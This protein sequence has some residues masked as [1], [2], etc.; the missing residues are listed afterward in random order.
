MKTIRSAILEKSELRLVEMGKQIV[1]LVFSPE[2]KPLLKIEG[3][4][5][6]EVWQQLHDQFGISNPKY[7]GYDGAVSKVL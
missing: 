2:G 6:D 4:I 5:A 1:G 3:T 7:F